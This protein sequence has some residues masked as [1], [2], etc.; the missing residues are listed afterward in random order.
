MHEMSNKQT[1][2]AFRFKEAVIMY[3]FGLVQVIF[4]LT[5]LLWFINGIVYTNYKY[6]HVFDI[7]L[8][9]QVLVANIMLAIL[10]LG[11]LW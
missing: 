8:A 11:L 5:C 3:T 2:D 6:K 4:F 7:V 10:G 1:R 9:T